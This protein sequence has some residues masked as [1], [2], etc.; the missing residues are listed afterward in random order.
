MH[1]FFY[2]HKLL[3]YFV[4]CVYYLNRTKFVQLILRKII[5]IV[6]SRCLMVR[7]KCIKFDFGWGSALDPAVGAYSAHPDSKLD[8]S[9]GG[10]EER[11]REGRGDPASA[12]DH[13]KHC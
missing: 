4:I 2:K 10:G 13:L 11:K 9:R 1:I 5:I 7:L 6:A 8:L 3:S 12:L